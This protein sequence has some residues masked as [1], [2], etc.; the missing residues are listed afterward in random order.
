MVRIFDETENMVQ[1]WLPCDETHCQQWRD[2]FAASIIGKYYDATTQ[3]KL[4][5]I[6]LFDRLQL[7]VSNAQGMIINPSAEGVDECIMCGY[8]A[9]AGSR[10]RIC[11]PPGRTE[12]C[13]PGCVRDADNE[14]FWCSGQPANH[15]VW[16][17]GKPWKRNDLGTMLEFYKGR[18]QSYAED[19]FHVWHGNELYNEIVIDSECIG[20]HLPNAIEAFFYSNIDDK[21][22]VT[23]AHERFLVEFKLT[24]DD[25]PL[26]ALDVENWDAP[27][28]DPWLTPTEGADAQA[29]G[30]YAQ[31]Q[32]ADAP[33]QH[34]TVQKRKPW[35]DPNRPLF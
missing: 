16:C 30:A 23:K 2:R 3:A 17:G 25:V 12:T 18:Q 31:A 15:D 1:P 9:D 5:K 35:E 11:F 6:G 20:S 19:A 7:G 14:L 27:F 28:A 33:F 26:L 10:S 34:D 4:P 22:R 8:G 24:P 32:G 13:L 29:Q 21:G